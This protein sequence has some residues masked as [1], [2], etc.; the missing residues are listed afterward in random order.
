MAAQGFPDGFVWGAATSAYQI[1][2]SVRADGRGESIWDRFSHVAG[3]VL[4]EDTGDVAC[5]HYRRWR[6]DISLMRELQ[7]NAYRFSIAW[8][9]IVPTGSGAVNGA[10]IDFYDR[11]V[12]ELLEA[13]I[14][15]WPTLYHWDLPQPLQDAGGWPNRATVDRFLDM[16]DVVTRRLGDR[17]SHWMTINEPLIAGHFGH[18]LG[19]HA[20]GLRSWRAGLAASHHML[21]AHG[22]AVDIV[23]TNAGGADVG[24]V[25]NPMPAI[26]ADDSQAAADAAERWDGIANR[27][28]LQALSGRGYPD[29]VR[30]LFSDDAP[31]VR[32]DDLTVIAAPT[33]FLGV[34]YYAPMY[35]AA[36]PAP[37]GVAFA[38]P[39]PDIA[40]TGLGWP[41]QPEVFLFTL[42]RIQDEFYPGPI[43]I[44]ENGAA[45]PD[46]PVDGGRVAVGDRIDYLASHLDAVWRAIDGGIPVRGYF[47]WSLLDNF[48]WANGYGTRFG[49]VHV[50]YATQE[51]TIKESGRWYADV[52]AG[53]ELRG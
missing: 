24:I 4:G 42:R 3:N 9:R 37:T 28:Y 40:V 30:E 23:R 32:D 34:N 18:S 31:D 17:V 38:G 12:D 15:P 20:P 14:A 53:N 44:A 25:I 6:D 21:L 27:W 35:V 36:G 52:V 13:D 19:I 51:R 39:P 29:D 47:P 41:I 22:R 2:G 48:E 16:V 26:P 10:G 7:L 43:V 33:D 1:E 50:D 11:L 49:L 8:P 5:D 46:P 45:F